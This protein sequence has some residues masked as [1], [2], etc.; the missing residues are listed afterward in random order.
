VRVIVTGS[1]GYIGCILAEELMRHGHAV[2]GVDAGFY[3]SGWLYAGVA[4][5][6]PTLLR[7]IRDLDVDDLRGHDAVVH[8]AELSNDPVGQLNPTMTRVINHRGS[9]GLARR[10]RE[11]GVQ[12][13]VYMSSTSVYGIQEGTVVNE[14]SRVDPRTTYAE[15]KVSVERDIAALEDDR[16]HPTFLR[17]AT[18]YGA[19]PRMRFDIVLN[20]LMGAAWTEKEIAVSS[21][22]TPW[23]PIAHIRD[24]A[25]AT[26]L[27][28]EADTAVVHNE[29][30]NVGSDEQNYQVRHLAELVRRAVPG[31]TISFG[32]P[33]ADQRSYRVSFDKIR[34]HLPTFR[35]SWDAEAGVAEL[36]SVFRAVQLDRATFRARP[37][38]RLDQIVHLMRTHQV[39]EDLRWIEPLALDGRPA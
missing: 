6:P 22:G 12:R 32:P 35:C 3:R 16:F 18:A 10:A 5:T 27:V 26:R 36:A 1:D 23:R 24:T 11:A 7:D 31:C 17:N 4:R 34:R 39:T 19:S 28:L 2:V 38:T 21:D 9:V 37:F 8:L 13:F 25:R 30:F 20:N 14:Q 33:S 15:C 29:I